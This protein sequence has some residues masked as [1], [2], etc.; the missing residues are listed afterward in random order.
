MTIASFT[1]NDDSYDALVQDYRDQ[2][3]HET[4]R[5]AFTLFAEALGELTLAMERTNADVLGEL[6]ERFSL[7]SDQFAQYFTPEAVCQTLAAA[8]LPDETVI[9]EATAGDPLQIGDPTCGSGRL[10]ITTA[11]HLRQVAP[12]TPAVFV[13]QD[14]D[15]ICAR[16]AVVNFVLFGVSGFVVH[17]DSLTTEVYCSWRVEPAA[18]HRGD[19]IVRPCPR[20][21]LPLSAVEA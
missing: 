1:T 3:G 20:S 10:L 16:M 2:H 8:T 5:T 21:D 18:A 6:Y 17:G 9:Q 11:H 12:K 7:T 13:G 14:I 15:G 19:P 4:T